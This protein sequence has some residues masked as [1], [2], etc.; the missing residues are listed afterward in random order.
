M[1]TRVRVVAVRQRSYLTNTCSHQRP[2]PSLRSARSVLYTWPARSC[3][4]RTTTTSTG[5]STRT[6]SPVYLTRIERRCAEGAPSVV[7]AKCR[8]G[9]RRAYLLSGT[10]TWSTSECACAV[11]SRWA[12]PHATA[13]HLPPRGLL[14]STSARR[15]RRATRAAS[16]RTD[17]ER[18]RA[19]RRRPVCQKTGGVL[20]SQALA[21]Q[22]PSA[23]RGLTALFGMGRGVSPSPR[24]P[25]KGERPRLPRSLKTTQSPRR[26]SKNPSSP[27]PISTGLLRTLPYF[28]IRPINLVVYQGSYSL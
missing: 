9:R 8:H 25:E 18:R 1:R 3:C 15:A 10:A 28:Q 20:L 11:P 5:R 19:A 16:P 12:F 27:R 17:A 2:K 4:S 23:L 21:G 24:P 22:V 6:S 26:V 13:V 7:S 14:A